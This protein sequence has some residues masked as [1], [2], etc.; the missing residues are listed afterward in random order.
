VPGGPY[1]NPNLILKEPRCKELP[2]QDGELLVV[3]QVQQQFLNT[4]RP[5]VPSCS[6]AQAPVQVPAP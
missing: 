4:S 1:P 2:L 6:N 5:A 3:G